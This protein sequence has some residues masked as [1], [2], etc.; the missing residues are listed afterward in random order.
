M[1]SMRDFF[2]ATE[3]VT[4]DLEDDSP[5]SFATLLLFDIP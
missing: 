5:I 4:V 3:R 2:S 1:T